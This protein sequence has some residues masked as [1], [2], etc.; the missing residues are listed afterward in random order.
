MDIVTTTSSCIWK[1]GLIKVRMNSSGISNNTKAEINDQ[2]HHLVKGRENVE[3][4]HMG[5][6]ELKYVEINDWMI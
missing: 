3:K 2:G 4:K 1:E 5:S 6:G